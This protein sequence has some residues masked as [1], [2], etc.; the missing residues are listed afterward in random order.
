MEV[1]MSP[2]QGRAAR[3]SPRASTRG[4]IA[5]LCTATSALVEEGFKHLNAA[6]IK[7]AIVGETITDGTHWSDKFK[8]DGTVESIMHGQVQNGRWRVRGGELCIADSNGKAQAE[9]CFEVWRS[10]RVIEY[11]RNGCGFAQGDL[12]NR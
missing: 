1:K 3:W 11:R 10:G 2:K 4:A 12:V 7:K 9:E 8:S 6:E 5:V